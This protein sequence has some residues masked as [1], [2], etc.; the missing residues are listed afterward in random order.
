MTAAR[1][2]RRQAKNTCVR[3][4]GVGQVQSFACHARL[5]TFD[6]VAQALLADSWT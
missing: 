5:P 4:P 6:Q 2:D 3:A 1:G